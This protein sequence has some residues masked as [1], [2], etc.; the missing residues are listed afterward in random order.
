MVKPKD[1]LE[2][3]D[4]TGVVYHIPCA[5]ANNV[6]C[7][8]TYVGETERTANARLSEHTSTLTNFVPLH[9]LNLFIVLS[10]SQVFLSC[11][12]LSHLVTHA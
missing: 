9:C 6:A 2:K 5:G 8:G 3:E 4:Q 1:K 12:S 7:S 11:P 10:L